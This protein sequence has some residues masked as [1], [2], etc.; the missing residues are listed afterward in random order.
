MFIGS[1]RFC[2]RDLLDYFDSKGDEAEHKDF[3][4]KIDIT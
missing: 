3:K 1:E 4:A 2:D